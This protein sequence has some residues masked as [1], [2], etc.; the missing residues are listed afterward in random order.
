M[1]RF[2]VS[3]L[4]FLGVALWAAPTFP[5]LSGR[6]VDQAG[7]L[8]PDQERALSELSKSIEDNSTAQVVVVTLK[9]LEGYD[10]AD[11]GYQLGRHW[12][13][14]QKGKDNG[15][16]IIVAP[17][18]HKV[19]IE[20]GYGLEG[21]ITDALSHELIQSQLIPR[22]KQQDVYGGINNTMEQIKN[23]LSHEPTDAAVA[24][25]KSEKDRFYWV[26]IAFIPFFFMALRSRREDTKKEP[27]TIKKLFGSLFMGGMSGTLVWVLSHILLISGIIALIVFIVTYFADKNSDFGSMLDGMDGLS[28][29]TSH[30]S[31][32]IFSGGGGSFGGGGASGSW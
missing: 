31:F 1:I 3:L 20:V 27:N 25:K 4:F 5:Q 7:L 13:I 26:V 21:S 8:T 30:D 22:F 2:F 9:S 10:I 15:L 28:G 24:D 19:R 17:N 6:V 12:G 23:I 11:Y 16:L 14:G 29:S 32:D 18:E